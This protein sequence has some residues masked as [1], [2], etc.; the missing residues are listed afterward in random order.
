MPWWTV[1]P[2]AVGPGDEP[3]PSSR[4]TASWPPRRSRP[5]TA[6]IRQRRSTTSGAG[7]R[8][9][10][11]SCWS[12]RGTGRPSASPRCCAMPASGVRLHAGRAGFT[13][14]DGVATVTTGCLTTGWTSELL[15]LAVLTE[16]DLAGTRG[17]GTKD[18]RGRM[19]SR[20]GRGID[21]LQLMPGDLVVHEQHG[22][23]RYL[24][25]VARTVAGATRDYLV[26]E[27]ARGDKLFVPDRP[28]RAGHPLRR[29]RGPEPRP[30]RRRRLGQAQGPG[31][32]GGQGDRGRADPALQR[33]D[34]VAR[35]RVRPRLAVAARARGRLPVP[36]DARPAAGRRRGQERHG[37]GASRW[38]G[39]SAATSATA[40][41][42]S[43]FARRSRR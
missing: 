23:G 41:P 34:G 42:R 1:T 13:L 8:P 11:A 36:R 6:A 3:T 15:K 25:M 38:T 27:Y 33:A 26:L 7:S 30:D 5:P 22:V 20:R 43:P 17:V 4:T 40:R 9:A 29:R 16:T 24:E 32:Q 14:D 12:P 21:P 28:A 19:P 39:W 35:S 2:F 37:S 18:L 10:G 31:A